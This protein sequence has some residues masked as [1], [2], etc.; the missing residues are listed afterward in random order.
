[1]AGAAPGG[2]GGVMMVVLKCVLKAMVVSMQVIVIVLV[3]MF[4]HPVLLVQPIGFRGILKTL[5]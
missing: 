4:S 3:R 1:M 5:K 2:C